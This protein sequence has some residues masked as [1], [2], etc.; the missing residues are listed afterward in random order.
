MTLTLES[1][2]RAARRNPRAL[3]DAVRPIGRG[4]R[5]AC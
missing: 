4:T 2:V 5:A 1:P 3:L